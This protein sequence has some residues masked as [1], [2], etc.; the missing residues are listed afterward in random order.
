M[1]DASRTGNFQS[2]LGSWSFP[3]A[4]RIS[5]EPRGAARTSADPQQPDA[6]ARIFNQDQRARFERLSPLGEYGLEPPVHRVGRFIRQPE[7]H[8]ARAIDDTQSENR[9]EVEIE[10]EQN[11]II[12]PR[13]LGQQPVR[14][15]LHR[16]LADMN[17]VMA[18]PAQEFDGLGRDPRVREEP[19]HF[20][21]GIG[22]TWS[23][24]M[25]AA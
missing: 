7:D 20:P 8:G 1:I 19:H 17:R 5:G 10:G 16:Q 9:S 21:A 22:W 23:S 3:G 2:P 24:A 4:L 14:G 13:L 11:A 25:A 15:A 12:R 18:A 6:I